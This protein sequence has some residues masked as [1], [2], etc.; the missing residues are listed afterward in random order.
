MLHATLSVDS[1]RLPAVLINM[2]PRNEGPHTAGV[3]SRVGTFLVSY[4]YGSEPG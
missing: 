3:S 2:T 1:E 4:L